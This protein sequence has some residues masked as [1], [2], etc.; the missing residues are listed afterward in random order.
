[1]GDDEIGQDLDM[2]AVVDGA[3]V[4]SSRLVFEPGDRVVVEEPG[5]PPAR[6]AFVA[7]WQTAAPL[8]GFERAVDI[9]VNGMGNTGVSPADPCLSV[10]STHV[11]QMINGSSGGYFR[12][13]DKNLA[14]LGA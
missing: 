11:I 14:S 6:E 5:Y 13:Y 7:A 3:R 9:S 12:I 10:G 4:D 8:H 2:V 1:M